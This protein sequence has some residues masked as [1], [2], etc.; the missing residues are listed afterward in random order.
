VSTSRHRIDEAAAKTTLDHS[1]RRA[2]R[3]VSLWVPVVA[4]MAVIFYLSS[5]HDP[6]P[7]L[8]RA[9]WDKAL[10]CAEY[11]G[12]AVLLGRAFLGEGVPPGRAFL[13]AVVI[14]SLYAASDEMHQMWVQGRDAAILDWLAGSAG[15]IAGAALYAVTARFGGRGVANL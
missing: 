3:H 5:Q 10:H 13:A 12:L 15:A 1:S 11:A 9:V 4:Y 7:D 6:L 8:T 14:S 2:I